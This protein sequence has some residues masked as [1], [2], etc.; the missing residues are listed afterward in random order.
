MR[1][2]YAKTHSFALTGLEAKLVEVEVEIRRGLRHFQIVGL[3]DK[4]IEE[5]KERISSALNSAGFQTPRSGGFRVLVNLAPADLKKEGSF[6]D[7]AIALAFLK[8]SSQL[9]ID[10][11]NKAIFGEL[12]LNGE[13]KP[14]RGGVAFALLAQERDL[15]LVCPLD[16]LQQLGFIPDFKAFSSSDLKELVLCLQKREPVLVSRVDKKSDT[17][18]QLVPPWWIKGQELAKRA[19]VV[20]AGGGHHLLLVGPPGT[21]KTLLA[22]SLLYLLPPLSYQETLELTKIYSVADL[23]NSDTPFVTQRPFRAPHHSSSKPALVGGGT[24]PRVGEITL[25]HKGVLFLDEFAEFRRDVLEALRQPLEDKV[26]HIS[27][28]R[29]SVNYPADFVLVASSNPCPCGYWGDKLR[30]CKC[31]YTQRE[32]YQRKLR[33]PLFDRLDLVVWVDRVQ[34][35]DVLEQ[36]REEDIKQEWEE[37]KE[38]IKRARSLQIQRQGK[39]NSELSPPEIEKHIPLPSLLKNELLDYLER[40]EITMRGFHKIIKVAR[41]I[42][43]L[44]QKPAVE[45]EDVFEALSFREGAVFF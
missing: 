44:K 38:R 24:P 42:A 27:R 11:E 25:A 18:A 5:A 16:N 29:Y 31:L 21:G 1:E 22:R 9:E 34:R 2:G 39:L 15:E 12:S 32:S 41:T 14:T 7:L 4:A 33:G 8:A 40:G 10:L 17:E 3:A 37:I 45:R 26:I 20:V 28:A 6:L 35:D 36:K 19:L 30:A 43:D 13:I 23:L